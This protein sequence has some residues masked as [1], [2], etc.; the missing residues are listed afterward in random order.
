MLVNSKKPEGHL[1]FC[2]NMRYVSW[3]F[4]LNINFAKSR[5]TN[6]ENMVGCL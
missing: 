1:L 3:F 5:F 2:L 4:S 6:F